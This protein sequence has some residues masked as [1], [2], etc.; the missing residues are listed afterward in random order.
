MRALTPNRL[1]LVAVAAAALLVVGAGVS[2]P[3][4]VATEGPGCPNEQLRAES[5]LNPNTDLPYSTELPDC[6]AYEMVSP[7]YTEGNY[8]LVTAISGDGSR[9][10]AESFGK[11][12]GDPGQDQ[13]GAIY[14]FARTPL[15]WGTSV[16][17]PPA[18]QAP[19]DVFF[20]PSRDFRTSLWL[21]SK[22]TQPELTSWFYIR[23]PAGE[24][25]SCPPGAIP[26]EDACFVEIGPAAPPS[27][28]VSSSVYVGASGDLSH[29][30]FELEGRELWP[31]DTTIR[32][33]G[34]ESLYEYVRTGNSEPKLVGVSNTG[35]VAHN[36]EA[37]LISDCKTY[38]GALRDGN[39][40]YN[41]MS[42]SGETLFFTAIGH[43]TPECAPGTK[44]PEAT[45]LYA[46][47][48]QEETVAISE[49]VL[50]GGA[51][52]ECSGG[53]PCA[54]ATPEEGVF[55]GAS[56]DGE[57]VFLP[58]RTAARERRRRD[59]REAL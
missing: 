31:G 36:E 38:L 12:A 27:I 48:G 33:P 15:G 51:G 32:H 43:S 22:P 34:P 50:P 4:A 35:K 45:G 26:V 5:N 6:R 40:R 56:E 47:I 17:N 20:T 24:D 19:E 9:L 8:V 1:I 2:A 39:E 13:F 14:E 37:K 52:G 54:G 41:A 49:P 11:F 46:R 55:R 10:I 44:A 53:E 23:E 59:G 42:I 16:L 3:P 28:V 21:L 58:L 18:S 57:R 29:I 25:G 30:A 7:P